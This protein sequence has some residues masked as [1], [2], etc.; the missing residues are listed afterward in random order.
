MRSATLAKLALTATVG[1]GAL[2]GSANLA[3]AGVSPTGGTMKVAPHVDPGPKDKLAPVPTT[4]TTITPMGG[5]IVNPDPEPQP[6]PPFD[7][8]LPIAQPEPDDCYPQV[9]CDLA[10]VPQD[11][12]HG[13]NELLVNC[14]ELAQPEPDC[15]TTHGCPGEPCVDE[16]GNP[17]CLTDGGGTGGTDGT[18]GTDGSGDEGTTGGSTGGTDGTDGHGGRLPHTGLDTMAMVGM[19]LG[20][21]GAGAALKRLGRRSK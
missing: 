16:H 1:I 17:D 13:C 4:S 10:P 21:T 3:S 2:I 14:D 20:L 7:P 19:G 12:D 5:V 6:D 11:V 9:S 8:D 15:N 18:D